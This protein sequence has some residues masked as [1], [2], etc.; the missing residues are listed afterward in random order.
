MTVNDLERR[1]ERRSPN[2]SC[3]IPPRTRTGATTHGFGGFSGKA[4]GVAFSPDAAGLV[5]GGS[6]RMMPTWDAAPPE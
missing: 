6:L 3:S 2:S 1:A 5:T 4:L